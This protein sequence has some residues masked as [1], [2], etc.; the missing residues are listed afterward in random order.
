[1]KK[2]VYKTSTWLPVFPGF[3]GTYFDTDDYQINDD[4]EEIV[5]TEIDTSNNEGLKLF[6]ET[7]KY[8]Y[9]FYYGYSKS[10]RESWKEYRQEVSECAVRYMKNIL[11]A[12]QYI[13]D[14]Q[15]E[16]LISTREYNFANDSI[17]IIIEYDDECLEHIK[18]EIMNRES[19][20][21][22]YLKERYTSRS[23]FISHHSNNPKDTEWQIE[24]AMTDP[25]NAGTV[26]EFISET[27][28]EEMYYFV[29]G[30]TGYYIDGNA[31]MKEFKV[32]LMDE[33]FY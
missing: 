26:L 13:I 14:M 30:N 31:L 28:S 23:G 12:K 4:L 32:W 8:L 7:M 3:Y 27:D 24:Y 21:K 19:E 6:E 1:M 16:E 5:R 29:V 20:W 15:F 9:Q 22:E 18:R 17:N 33:L 25:H 10:Q 11:C 2:T